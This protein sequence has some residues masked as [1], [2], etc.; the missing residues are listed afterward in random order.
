MRG[1]PEVLIARLRNRKKRIVAYSIFS[2]VCLGL[3]GVHWFVLVDMCR[4]LVPQEG[5]DLALHAVLSQQV[6]FAA[7]C[8]HATSLLLA[9]LLGL[10][11][12]ALVCEVMTFTKNDL[13]VELWDRVQALE[14]S[15]PPNTES[16][17]PSP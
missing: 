8:M 6:F 10:A 14:R 17:I 5:E 1:S 7:A 15:K 9:C 11:V 12:G 13:L 4:S 2:V 3:L 16:P